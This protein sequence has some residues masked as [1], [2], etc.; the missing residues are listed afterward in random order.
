MV[1]DEHPIHLVRQEAASCVRCRE[2]G[3]VFRHDDGKW[4]LPLFHKD[5]TCPSRIVLVAEAP[6]VMVAES[7][8]GDQSF[9]GQSAKSSTPRLLIKIAFP[10]NL[11]RSSSNALAKLEGSLLGMR[12]ASA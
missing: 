6:N 11:I 8:L 3:L 4:A 7:S 10:I 12:A 2:Q 1:G 9:D 5:A